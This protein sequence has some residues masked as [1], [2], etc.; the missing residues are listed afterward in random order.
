MLVTATD[1]HEGNALQRRS[2]VL[3]ASDPTVRTFPLFLPPSDIAQFP[4]GVLAW[5]SFRS[6]TNKRP[7]PQPVS[8]AR[9]STVASFYEPDRNYSFSA[10]FLLSSFTFSSD[11]FMDSSKPISRL[12]LVIGDN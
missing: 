6:D 4:L 8:R 10:A 12:P 11:D 7:R 1:R 2:I 9:L 3:L 5:W